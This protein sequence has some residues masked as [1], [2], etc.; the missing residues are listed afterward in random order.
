MLSPKL[1]TQSH[2]TSGRG[3]TVAILI[4][5]SSPKRITVAILVKLNGSKFT[6]LLLLRVSFAEGSKKSLREIL[7]DDFFKRLQ[8]KGW[9]D[10]NT[11]EIWYNK[12]NNL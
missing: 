4:D 11:M 5:K 3:R 6:F 8:R 10:N 1:Y 12:V 7:P 2:W 9:V